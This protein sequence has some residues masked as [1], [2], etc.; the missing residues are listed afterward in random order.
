MSDKLAVFQVTNSGMDGMGK[1]YIEFAS[2]YEEDR[3][4]Y[5]E[6]LGKNKCYYNKRDVVLSMSKLGQ[7]FINKLNG[8]DKMIL[9]L[10]LCFDLQRDTL[11]IPIGDKNYTLW[12]PKK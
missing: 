7:D 3:D 5:F 9:N 2:L 12:N 8:N 11:T 6:E 1:M 4:H 10:G